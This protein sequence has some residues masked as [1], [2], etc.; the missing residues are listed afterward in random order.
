MTFRVFYVLNA[1]EKILFKN[2]LNYFCPFFLNTH[3][4]HF[5]E[6]NHL[7]TEGSSFL[8]NSQ[9]S[10]AG[11]KPSVL[12]GTPDI[13]L[14]IN[15][16][17][18]SVE[19]SIFE[20]YKPPRF[21]F[22]FDNSS[23]TNSE[24]SA[25]PSIDVIGDVFQEANVDNIENALKNS[26]PSAPEATFAENCEK[27]IGFTTESVK[28]TTLPVEHDEVEVFSE[29]NHQQQFNDQSKE[30][31][32][33]YEN[34]YNEYQYNEYEE[35][36]EETYEDLIRNGVIGNYRIGQQL[37][38]GGFGRVYA[39]TT[40][41]GTEVAVKIQPAGDQAKREVEVMKQL[42]H[43]N[44]VKFIETFPINSR[45]QWN[46]IVMEHANQGCLTEYLGNDYSEAQIAMIVVPTLEALSYLE[47][48]QLAWLDLKTDNIL[49]NDG[50][51]K[52]CDFGMVLH[53]N[54]LEETNMMV[55]TTHYIA[56]EMGL[57]NT[58]HK[59]S[60]IWSLGVTVVYMITK[61]LPHGNF[62]G[63]RA[64]Q[65][66][67]AKGIEVPKD[68]SPLLHDFLTQVLTMDPEKRPTASMLLNHEWVKSFSF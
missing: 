60:D 19:S 15:D 44:I 50:Q 48:K 40:S 33:N 37:G 25:S 42:N 58:P 24:R 13:S 47:S 16:D 30:F 36:E 43:K 34:Q 53:Y 9:N 66:I 31:N 49:L 29:D 62:K 51:V 28:T 6:T 2:T 26:Q 14:R 27:I 18:S 35:Q 55:G 22:V 59:K 65:E 3:V 52:L 67:A 63:L 12:E 11:L 7:F 41:T 32:Q 23:E 39:A 61:K 68:V 57:T 17:A 54:N 1:N 45:F 4:Q 21:S 56:P 20:N 46:C 64:I 10:L 38:E 8:S 5:M